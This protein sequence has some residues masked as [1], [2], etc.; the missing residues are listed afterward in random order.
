M[1][2]RLF[3]QAEANALLPQIRPLMAQLL[4]RQARVAAAHQRVQGMLDD[5]IFNVGTAES[6]AMVQDFI[7]IERLVNKIRAFGCEVKDIRV[8]LV[9][10][11]AEVNGREVYLCW[12]YNEDSITTYHDL[13]AGFAGRKPL[14]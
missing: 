13:D 12:R 5:V 8:G 7:I 10:F 14:A 6:S 2:S 3:T 1:T 11:L 4:E 9:D